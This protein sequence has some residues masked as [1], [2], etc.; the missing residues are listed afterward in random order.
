VLR[1]EF[2]ISK[3]SLSLFD[4]FNFI[5]VITIAIRMS[6]FISTLFSSQ[7]LKFKHVHTSTRTLILK[8]VQVV[9]YSIIG[10]IGLELLGIDLTAFTVVA[11]ALSVGIGFG[12]QK[13]T[14][15][16]IS[17]IILLVEQSIETGDV[18]EFENNEFG[19]VR[20]LGGRYSLV[21]MFDGKEVMIPNEDLITQRVTNWTFSNPTGRVEINVGVSYKADIHLVK[22]L[23]LAAAAEYSGTLLT[24]KPMC[25][26]SEFGDSSVNFILYFFIADVSKGR[27]E[28][29]SA[30]MFAI[31]DKFKENDIEIP[32]PQRD[33]HIKAGLQD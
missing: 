17:G 24:P 28:P 29:K 3:Y 8:T 25:L 1:Y 27:Y 14:S 11:G 31:W 30:V 9:T 15:N 32:F 16:F 22:E 21:E 20:K 7:L 12:L 6:Q 19:T 23:M 2:R 18:L 26:L 10:L 13:I 5:V 4:V 33:I